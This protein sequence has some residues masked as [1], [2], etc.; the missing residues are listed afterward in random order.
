MTKNVPNRPLH[1]K[2][3]LLKEWQCCLIYVILNFLIGFNSAYLQIFWSFIVYSN[4]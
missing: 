4:S 2:H 3:N 1:L